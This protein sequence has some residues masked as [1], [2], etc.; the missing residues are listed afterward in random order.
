LRFSIGVHLRL[1][2]VSF[3]YQQKTKAA[4]RRLCPVNTAETQ[5]VALATSF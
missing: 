4:S 2:A 5:P 1:S 3:S